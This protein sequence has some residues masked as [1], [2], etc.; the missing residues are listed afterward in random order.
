MIQPRVENSVAKLADLSNSLVSYPL[1]R[2]AA[3]IVKT[4]RH[5]M[6]VF[7]VVADQYISGVPKHIAELHTEA[8]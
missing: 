3:R 5:G 4:A 1:L 7:Y 8:D 2:R 6:R